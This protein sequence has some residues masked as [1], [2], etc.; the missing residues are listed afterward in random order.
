MA[1]YIKTP[2]GSFL[3]I[4][5]LN[6]YVEQMTQAEYDA[7]PQAT[8]DDNHFRVVVNPDGDEPGLQASEI[9]SDDG[10]VQDDINA[11]K[12]KKLTGTTRAQLATAVASLTLD[13]LC[14]S[15]LVVNGSNIL[16]FYDWTS[17]RTRWA[18]FVPENT[19]N[20]LF[21]WVM[22]NSSADGV[23]SSVKTTTS[24]NQTTETITSWALYY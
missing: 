6:V 14:H 5:G 10:N 22:V 2:N 4:G 23:V 17:A 3:P 15:V 12:R 13:V 19:T 11:C 18:R 16:T 7:L 8:Q 21:T 24:Y 20:A 1:E 9:V